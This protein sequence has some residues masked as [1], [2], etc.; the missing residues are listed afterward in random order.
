MSMCGRV[1]AP[2]GCGCNGFW[3]SC[4]PRPPAN[5]FW[6]ECTPPG[7]VWDPFWGSDR[8]RPSGIVRHLWAECAPRLPLELVWGQAG[9]GRPRPSKRL[10]M[11]TGVR[12]IGHHAHERLSLFCFFD[13]SH[14]WLVTPEPHGPLGKFEGGSRRPRNLM[15]P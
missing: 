5:L 3:G 10:R 15:D 14:S 4:R 9:P 12:Q 1:Y 13:V 8:P 2:P 11:L 7:C 6:A